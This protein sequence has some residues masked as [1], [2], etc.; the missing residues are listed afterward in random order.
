MHSFIQMCSVFM[1]NSSVNHLSFCKPQA[2][3]A[4]VSR[5][6]RDADQS[7]SSSRQTNEQLDDIVQQLQGF[8]GQ[9]ESKHRQTASQLQQEKEQER[10]E[11]SQQIRR[12]REEK[13]HLQTQCQ[14]AEAALREKE[15]QLSEYLHVL[16]IQPGELHMSNKTLGSGSY[17]GKTST[18]YKLIINIYAHVVLSVQL[19]M[20]LIGV[21]LMLL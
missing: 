19:F 2:P 4:V 13:A 17:G 10:E 7:K 5:Q 16:D 14:T 20:W 1:L 8:F 3:T 9:L 6:S 11:Y 21:V 12:L 15:Q 18:S